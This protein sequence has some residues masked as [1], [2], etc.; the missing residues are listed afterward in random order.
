MEIIQK[1]EFE[2][3]RGEVLNAIK[4]GAILIYPTDTIYGIG[5]DATNEEAVIKLRKLKARAGHKPFSVIAPNK[6][7]ILEHC[8][9][10]DVD[11]LN[12]LPGPYTLIFKP[13]KSMDLAKSINESEDTVGVRIPDHWFSNIIS[14]A[15]I[16]FVTT[17]VNISDE[18][19]MIK[20]EDIPE[21]FKENVA[22]VIY[23]GEINGTPS[24]KINLSSL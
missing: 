11:I 16:P 14:E 3:Y 21:S 12:K 17:S 15:G 24:T 19:H 23:E 22:F 2:N 5:C 20:L 8:I 6:N 4:S 10:L 1:E 7:W 9:V 13:T 18:S